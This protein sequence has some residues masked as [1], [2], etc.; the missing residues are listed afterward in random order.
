MV[1]MTVKFDIIVAHDDSY[2]I[3]FDNELAWSLPEDMVFFR[4]L[5]SKTK[6]LDKQNIVFMGRKTY[7]SIPKKFRPLSNRINIVL[8]RSRVWAEEGVIVKN[9][10]QDVF[11][12]AKDMIQQHN[13]ENVFCIGGKEI[14]QSML[15]QSNCYRLYVTH[16]LKK[17]DCNV[18]LND[19]HK[20]FQQVFCSDIFESCN[21]KIPYQFQT[22]SNLFFNE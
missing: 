14:Y 16:I 9:N 11:D 17:F 3:G 7:E 8:T 21:E 6:S 19:Y 2:G 13:V 20:T 15:Q 10:I 18:F 12:Y 4:D 5:T 1:D 22:Y